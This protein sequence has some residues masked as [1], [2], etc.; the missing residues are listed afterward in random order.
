[1]ACRL[2]VVKLG[3]GVITDKSVPESVDYESLEKAAL[4]LAGYRGGGGLLVLVHGGGSFGHVEVARISREKGRLDSRD[5]SRVQEVMLKLAVTVIRVLEEKGLNP[6]LHPPHTLCMNSLP[7]TCNTS[8]I[9]RD[10]EEGL[11]PVTYGDAIPENGETRI[12]SGDDLAA[13]IA[14]ALKADCLVYIIR[15]PGVLDE[16]G[17]VIPILSNLNQ[18]KV[19]QTKWDDVTGGILRKVKT[20]LE[21]SK[22]IDNIIITN[23]EH[24]LEALER[25]RVGTKVVHM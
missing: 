5:S 21:A 20:A 14:V 6:S 25:K 13:W 4:Q 24:L 23:T 18:L 19:K 1:M 16:K 3:G 7:E 11:T 12:I 22:T 15:E 8:I 10:L 2:A 9:K 17:E